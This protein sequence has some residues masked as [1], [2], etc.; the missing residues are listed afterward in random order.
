VREAP[1]NAS[2]TRAG[3]RLL[4]EN[5]IFQLPYLSAGHAAVVV[6]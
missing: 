3:F 4:L 2:A 6:Q 1:V 5:V